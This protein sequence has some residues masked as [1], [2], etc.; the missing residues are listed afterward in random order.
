MP[1]PSASTPFLPNLN[2]HWVLEPLEGPIL[3]G[4][5]QDSEFWV[6]RNLELNFGK[7][8]NEGFM[9]FEVKGIW[10]IHGIEAIDSFDFFSVRLWMWFCITFKHYP[11]IVL[12]ET[13]LGVFVLLNVMCRRPLTCLTTYYQWWSNRTMKV[14]ILL[15]GRMI[16]ML[17]IFIKK[18]YKNNLTFRRKPIF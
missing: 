12:E 7:D 16:K 11:L 1:A 9:G 13:C 6:P 2:Q 3:D 5:K 14:A 8:R 4:L 10:K 17:P 18:I 15:N